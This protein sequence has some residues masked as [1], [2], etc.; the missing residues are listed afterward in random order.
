MPARRWRFPMRDA[1]YR[2]AMSAS[3]FDAIQTNPD[4]PIDGYYNVLI[5]ENTRIDH[6]FFEDHHRLQDL[7]P[8]QRLLIQLG[9][10]D[11]QVKNGGITQFFWNCVESIFDVADGIESL[12]ETALLDNYEQC[13]E[14]LV[15]KKDRWLALR[16]EWNQVKDAPGWETFQETYKLLDLGWFDKAYFDQSGY[17]ENRK[18]VRLRRGLHHSLM[19]RLAEYVRT[20]S[21]EFITG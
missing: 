14:A 4:D 10:F 6:S 3:A 15:G 17:D 19:T 11:S 7:T 18:W 8:G 16:V 21:R 2:A 9:T 12:G 5:D 20:H 13:L 1:D